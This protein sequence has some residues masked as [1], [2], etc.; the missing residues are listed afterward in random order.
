MMP[1]M[2][3]AATSTDVA[4]GLTIKIREIFIIT[5]EAIGA[6]NELAKHIDGSQ[7]SSVRA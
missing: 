7:G 5:S 3:I 4:T 2:I 6:L 1:K